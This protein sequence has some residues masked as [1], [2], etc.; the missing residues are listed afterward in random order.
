V[1]TESTLLLH[2]RELIQQGWTQHT[3]ARDTDGRAIQPWSP[4]AVAWSLLGALVAALEA[5][6]EVNEP[7]AVGRLAIA[8][9]TLAAVIEHDSLESWNDDPTRT[10]DDVLHALERAEAHA[11]RTPSPHAWD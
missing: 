7:L 10:P 6:T 2:A 8:C 1:P 11:A 9:V 4:H 5:E 3:D